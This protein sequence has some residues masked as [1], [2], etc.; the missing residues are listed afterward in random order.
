MPTK[1]RHI[2]DDTPAFLSMAMS[3]MESGAE[4]EAVKMAKAALAERPD[5]AE[6][7]S[8]ARTILSKGVHS[9]HRVML[10]DTPRNVAYRRAIDRYATGKIVLDIGTGSGL[11]A[12][13][14]VRAGAKH[15][16]ACE[17]NASKADLARDIIAANGM[18]DRISVI[19]KISLDLDRESDLGGGVDMV[20]S[21]LFSANVVG[22]TLMQALS[23]ATEELINPGR[24]SCPNAVRSWVP[25]HNAVR[26]RKWSTWRVSTCPCSISG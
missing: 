20:I 8:V 11:L 22:E 13:M 12:M 10:A 19:N 2:F 9:Y 16:Y 4:D 5:D 6:L 7:A 14:A 15:V 17:R 21:E 3:L 23:H 26:A 25:L 24:F 1:G 18:S